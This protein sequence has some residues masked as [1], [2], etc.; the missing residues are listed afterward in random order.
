MR[1]DVGGGSIR[2]LDILYFPTRLLVE[3]V[4]DVRGVGQVDQVLLA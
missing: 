2:I 4:A 1:T 3:S